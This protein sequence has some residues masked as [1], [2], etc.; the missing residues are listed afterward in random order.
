[1]ADGGTGGPPECCCPPGSWPACQSPDDYAAKGTEDKIGGIDVYY[2]G[3]PGDKAVLILPD[4]FGWVQNKG[5]FKGIADTL[6]NEGYFVLLS[7][8][9]YGDTAAGK[10][11]IMAWIAGFPYEKVGPD[12]VSCFKWLEEKGAK[13]I[14][15]VGFCWGV[16]AMCKAYSCGVSFACGVGAHPSTRLEGMFG[17]DEQAMMEKVAMPLLLLPAG[18]DPDN[19]KEGGPIAEAV[20]KQGGLSVTFPEMAHGWVSR[21]DL[22][23]EAVKRDVEAAMKLAIDFLKEKL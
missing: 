11:D 12:M 10:D 8:P 6:A 1:M 23:D 7:D 20:K 14:G 13:R 17:G 3:T 4:I 16:W 9:F 18:G 21:G 15:V 2:S 19:L 22:A 5:R